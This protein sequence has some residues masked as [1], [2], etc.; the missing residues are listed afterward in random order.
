MESHP[1]FLTLVQIEEMTSDIP[2][3]FTLS[4][5]YSMTMVY[6]RRCDLNRYY[7][8]GPTV[9]VIFETV[10]SETTQVLQQQ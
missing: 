4:V 2:G 3:T 5:I 7:R 1:F 8:S 9:N 6:P 10:L